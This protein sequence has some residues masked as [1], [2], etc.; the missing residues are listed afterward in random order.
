MKFH[1]T[2]F[3]LLTLFIGV[4]AYGGFGNIGGLGGNA[5]KNIGK[6][7]DTA[8]SMVVI[9]QL[10]KDIRKE[11]CRFKNATTENETTCS[12]SKV[13]G[14][15]NKHRSAVENVFGKRVRLE[16]TANAADRSLANK[17]A[18]NIRDDLSGSVSWW[19][20]NYRGATGGDGLEVMAKKY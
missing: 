19:R 8:G 17:R 18:R 3:S 11:G 4:H 15:I 10:N 20:I 14:I 13:A 9:D 5:G 2:L 6:S 16:V 12:M 1:I 7:L